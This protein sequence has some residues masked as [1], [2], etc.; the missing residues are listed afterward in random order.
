MLVLTIRTPI[1]ARIPSSAGSNSSTPPWTATS[2][3]AGLI[4]TL[5]TLRSLV[6]CYH[7]RLGLIKFL[8]GRLG[9]RLV[10]EFFG[11]DL[12]PF[13]G[14]GI[15]REGRY[16][17]YEAVSYSWGY[18]ARTAEIQVDGTVAY[19][20]P[21]MADALQYLRRTAELG[22]LWCDGSGVMLYACILI[23]LQ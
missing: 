21:S 14:L 11:A 23:E 9:D 2:R 22:W 1:A 4:Q 17:Q 13:D 8:P 12:T 10:A 19:I 16:Q 7:G 3:V 15:H 18:P 6:R 5:C 20:P